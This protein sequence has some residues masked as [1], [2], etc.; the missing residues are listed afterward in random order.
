MVFRSA[1][2]DLPVDVSEKSTEDR[3]ESPSG[4]RIR[5]PRCRWTPTEKHVWTC[6]CGHASN[7]FDTGGVCPACLYQW[8]ETRVPQVVAA[9]G[10]VF[11]NRLNFGR[12]L[13]R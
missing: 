8:T 10:L 1:V 11:A 2:L 13:S 3:G 9:F 12:A 5:C 6:G 4:P 7:T